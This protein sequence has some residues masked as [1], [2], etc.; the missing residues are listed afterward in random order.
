MGYRICRD[1]IWIYDISNSFKPDS[2]TKKRDG[3]QHEEK[4]KR[5]D[6]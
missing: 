2:K 3:T 6:N 1:M 5:E 4:M